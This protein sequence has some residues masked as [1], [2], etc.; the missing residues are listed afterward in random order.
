MRMVYSKKL[1]A[2][3]VGMKYLHVSCWSRCPILL[4]NHLLIQILPSP[5]SDCSS[6]CHSSFNLGSNFDI[7]QLI[8]TSCSAVLFS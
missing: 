5:D 3:L 4:W 6:I 2:N 7:M 8:Q 1:V